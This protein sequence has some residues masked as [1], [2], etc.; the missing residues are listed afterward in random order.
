MS[1]FKPTLRTTARPV[2]RSR[3]VAARVES[4]RTTEQYKCLVS[5]PGTLGAAGT[6]SAGAY[7]IDDS[8]FQAA[9]LN[10]MRRFALHCTLAFIFFRFSYL[11][12]FLSARYGIVVPFLLILGA[13]S[14][15]ACL[16]SGTALTGLQKRPVL[17]WILFGACMCLATVTSTYHRGS[18]NVLY[19]YL[20]TTLPLVLLIPAVA[21]TGRDIQKIVDTIGIAGITV[22][23]F[24][25]WSNDFTSGRL[26]LDSTGGTIQ[27][28]NDY[29][30]HMLLVL[31][32]VAY[33][34]LRA[35]RNVVIK[36]LGICAIGGGFY[37][38]LS[39]GS[40]GGLVSIIL[41]GLYLLKKG[42]NRLRAGLIFG[43]PLLFAFALPFIPGEAALRLGSLFSSKD[44]A[45]VGEAVASQEAR[46][47][48]LEESLKITIAHPLLGI[49]PGEFQDFQGLMASERGE[50][51]MWHETHNGYTQ[52]S[53]ECGIPAAVFY[54][55]AILMTFRSLRKSVKAN[56]SPISSIAHTL[57]VM[58]V[59]FLICLF[60]LSQGYGFALVVFTGLSVAIERLLRQPAPVEVMPVGSNTTSGLSAEHRN[61]PRD[62]YH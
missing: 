33:C 30:A 23:V 43:I 40:R 17:M 56:V 14:Y 49:G 38:L 32:A 24:G 39:T 20:R 31:P 45:Q 2:E 18:L 3:A 29:A 9:C 19:D 52:V 15:L 8:Q 55:A 50:H 6:A 46:T 62:A 37:G 60:F 35:G 25:L 13:V 11:H 41:T 59:G 36:I 54:I 7:A 5:S 4:V 47:A 16:L 57:S 26:Q 21:Y 12:E 44:Q 53:S 1:K 34:T 28:A 61:R 42:S 51:G 58:M 27:N 22:I 48:L 10:M